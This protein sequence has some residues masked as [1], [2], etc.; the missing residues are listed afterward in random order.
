MRRTY[1]VTG[2][3][4][5]IGKAT[6]EL[7]ESCGHRVVGVDLHDAEVIADLATRTG[8]LSLVDGVSAVTGGVVDAVIAC[9][10]VA[11]E[12]PD[13]VRVNYFGT[14]ATLEGLRPLLLRGTSPRAVVVS[15][16]AAVLA[17]DSGIVQACLAGDEELA[18]T[19]A[20]GAEALAY[21]SSKAALC[22]WVRRT[23][24]T[25]DWAGAGIP[26]NAAAPGIVATPATAHFLDSGLAE[27][28]LDKAVPMPFGGHGRP[29]QVANL[30]GWLAG[31]ENSMM[32]GQV[33]FIDGGADA[34]LRGDSVW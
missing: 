2:S 7:L 11:Y 20:K 26:L 1:V 12:E 16:V 27:A 19:A 13:T 18:V 23:A 28:V 29:E 10:G 6:R 9:A 32:I 17:V 21:A 30:L 33:L 22:R 15:S 8:R 4:A 24:V 34:V 31:P 14:V 3:A 5:G 25:E